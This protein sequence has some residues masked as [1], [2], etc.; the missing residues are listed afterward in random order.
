MV[1]KFTSIKPLFNRIVTT[2]NKHE[3][4]TITANG[5]TIPNK[6]AIMEYQTVVAVGSSVRDIKVGDLVYINPT[7][8]AKMKHKQGSLKDGVMGD[9]PVIGYEFTT[10]MLGDKPHLLLYDSDVDFI[11]EESHDEPNPIIQ[12][13]DKKIIR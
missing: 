11:I 2:M 6:G 13:F 12:L 9:N 8:Y 3:E 1:K 5:I 7:R 10:V 4:D